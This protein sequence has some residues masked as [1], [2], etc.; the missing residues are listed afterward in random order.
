MPVAAMVIAGIVGWRIHT[1]ALPDCY[2]H[3]IMLW[4]VLFFPCIFPYY[5]GP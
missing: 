1:P 3:A 4:C 5:G 2:S